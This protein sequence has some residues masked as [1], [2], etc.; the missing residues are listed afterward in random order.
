GNLTL[1]DAALS[2][3]TGSLAIGNITANNLVLQAA[4]GNLTQST[5]TSMRVKSQLIASASSGITF[6]NSGNQI[7]GFAANN[8]GTGDITLKNALNT[9]DA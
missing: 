6:N 7:A 4:N 8:R 1:A 3:A 5:G 2:Q 9:S